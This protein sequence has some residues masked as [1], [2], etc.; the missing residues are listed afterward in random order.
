MP[1]YDPTS[2]IAPWIQPR[3]IIG[4]ILD[5]L[6]RSDRPLLRREI[7]EAV[8][9]PTQNLSGPLDR[10]QR[11]RFLRRFK[12]PITMPHSA[13]PGQFATRQLWLYVATHRP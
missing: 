4:P 10:L 5:T 12:A 9:V 6:E 2:H 3:S 13:Y 1:A 8:D 7:A 11:Y